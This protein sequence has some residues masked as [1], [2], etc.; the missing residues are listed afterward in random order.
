MQNKRAK[1]FMPFAPLKGFKEALREK[2]KVI[3]PKRVLTSDDIDNL[4]YKFPQLKKGMIVKVVYYSDGN[5]IELEGMV[6]KIDNY[7][8]ILT[9]VKT[10]IFY[11]EILDINGKDIQNYR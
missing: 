4:N 6:S 11:N 9:I 8:K 5:Y 10:K 2:E 1:Q 7:N 3:V